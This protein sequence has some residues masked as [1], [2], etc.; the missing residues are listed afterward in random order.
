MKRIIRYIVLTLLLVSLVGCASSTPQQ[1]TEVNT[2]NTC[3]KNL[4]T[5][6]ETYVGDMD[7]SNA[8]KQCEEPKQESVTK[9]VLMYVI[10]YA[11]GFA[12]GFTAV[13][14]ILN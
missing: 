5:S 11:V 10:A 8:E 14:L 12:I 3:E 6:D 9:S 4:E 7:F 2:K 1:T 13:T